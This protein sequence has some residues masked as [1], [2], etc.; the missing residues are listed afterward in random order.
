MILRVA[1]PTIASEN[2]N[3][4][5]HVKFKYHF[6]LIPTYMSDSNRIFPGRKGKG[7]ER[8][9]LSH[10]LPFSHPNDFLVICS[11]FLE[12]RRQDFEFVRDTHIYI[13]S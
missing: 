4:Y 8:L 10:R 5:V 3:S 7:F 2:T 11:D 9:P 1:P 13:S 6:I 12:G